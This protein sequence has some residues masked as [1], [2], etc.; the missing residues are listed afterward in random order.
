MVEKGKRRYE[1][2]GKEFMSA[3]KE[4]GLWK[5]VVPKDQALSVSYGPT[6]EEKHESLGPPSVIRDVYKDSPP[7]PIPKDF[8]CDTCNKQKSQHSAPPTVGIRTEHPFDKIHSD[9]SGRFNTPTLGKNEYYMTFVDDYTRYCWIYLLKSK[10]QALLA[11]SNFWQFTQTQFRKTIKE[12]HSDNGTEYVNQNVSLFLQK[13][14]TIH[15][16]SPP[17]HPELNGVAERINQT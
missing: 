9:L 16:T 2:D 13:N 1:K 17:H 7:L 6:Y 4:D 12:L 15:T 14:G 3:R 8:N 11:I 5:V 10:D